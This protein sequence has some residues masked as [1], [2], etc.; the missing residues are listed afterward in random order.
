MEDP[1]PY[2]P[3][4]YYR[5]K[6]YDINGEA[7]KYKTISLA[8]SLE[9]EDWISALFPNPASTYVN[10]IHSD[11]DTE[12][13]LILE[14]Y[15]AMGQLVLQQTHRIETKNTAISL[16][17]TALSNGL[18]TLKCVQGEKLSVKKLVVQTK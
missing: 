9:S 3:L 5:L 18:Y 14:L 8:R 13:P 10:L 17:L 15:N 12:N 2:Y 6:Q 7:T 16:D 11:P 1:N 4:T